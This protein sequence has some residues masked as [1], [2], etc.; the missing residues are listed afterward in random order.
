MQRDI[1]VAYDRSP[2]SI[3]A[4][5]RAC[6]LVS[7]FDGSVTAVYVR[8]DAETDADAAGAQEQDYPFE[9][10]QEVAEEWDVDLQTVT[11]SGDPIDAIPT[12]G[13]RHDVDVIHVG[14]RGKASHDRGLSGNDRG[15]LG[16]VAQGLI[17][18]TQI[19]VSVFDRG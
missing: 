16:S 3:N 5:D 1:L 15:P 7:T 12:F 2:E 8:E 6:E 19:P 14:H 17:E 13:E 4:L 10:A 9:E 18:A 11:L